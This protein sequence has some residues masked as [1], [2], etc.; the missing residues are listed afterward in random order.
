[1]WHTNE[2]ILENSGDKDANLPSRGKFKYNFIVILP[3]PWLLIHGFNQKYHSI[4]LLT[5]KKKMTW[6]WTHTVHTYIVQ[7]STVLTHE[8]LKNWKRPKGRL[9][10]QPMKEIT[11]RYECS[12][13]F[14]R[15]M[16]FQVVEDQEDGPL[17][18]D[19]TICNNKWC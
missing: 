10:L 14:L 5:K 4:Y 9:S 12:Q 16:R 19:L 11:C 17:W 2:W 6:K 3:Y 1:M 15:V 8:I 13:F 7:R 18:L